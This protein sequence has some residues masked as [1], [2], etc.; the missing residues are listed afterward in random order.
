MSKT[1]N[2]RTSATYAIMIEANLIDR[3]RNF[4]L[5]PGGKIDG[6]DPLWY[7]TKCTLAECN[8]VLQASFPVKEVDQRIEETL[9]LFEL[10]S[11]PVTWYVGPST[12]P[13]DLGKHLQKHGFTHNQ[14][15]LGMAVN[16]ERLAELRRELPDTGLQFKEVSSKKDLKKWFEVLSSSLMLPQK[17]ADLRFGMYEAVSLTSETLWRHFLG[18]RDS[19]VVGISSLFFGADVPGFYN[20]TTRAGYR[21]QGVGTF[22][23]LHTFAEAQKMG[24]EIGTLLTSYPEALR[25]YHRLGFEVYCKIGV[26]EYNPK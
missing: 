7:T 9:A 22:M 20:L 13:P 2:Y 25:L 11:M 24:Y 16:L 3:A 18:L 4:A 15:L 1:L 10:E 21:K 17:E 5:L 14:E 8:G 12:T 6:P 26:Y 23:T 19:K